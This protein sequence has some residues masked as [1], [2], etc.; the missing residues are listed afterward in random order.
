M[1]IDRIAGFVI[2]ILY[3]FSVHIFREW[4]LQGSNI[5]MNMKV[6]WQIDNDYNVINLYLAFFHFFIVFFFMTTLL[7]LGV[8][9]K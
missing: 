4:N 1:E 8:K 6:P 5:F 7:Q 2:F 9:K 3:L